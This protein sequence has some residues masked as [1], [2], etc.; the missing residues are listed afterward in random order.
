MATLNKISPVLLGFMVVWGVLIIPWLEVFVSAQEPA[1]NFTADRPGLGSTSFVIPPGY[2]QIE[3]GV[4]FQR[5]SGAAII[6]N[7]LFSDEEQEGSRTILAVPNT[8]FRIGILEAIEFRLFAGE[9]VHEDDGVD[10]ISP[11][12]MGTKIGLTK[13]ERWIPQTAFFLELTLPVGSERLRPDDV[14]P[15]FRMAGNYTIGDRLSWEGNLGAGW[16]DGFNDI[17]GFYTTALGFALIDELGVF[18]EFFGTMNGE[19]T[20]GFDGGISYLVRPT[21][22]LD[23]FGGPGLTDA[24]PDWFVTAGISFRLP[25]L[26]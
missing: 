17:T 25:Q 18:T 16:E 6:E 7:R 22:Q 10:G 2:V 12:I 20:H 23:V 14:T 5:A 19:S 3:T 26:W 11:L 4:S 9:Y 1:S 15:E 24:A 13:E 21:V 8:L